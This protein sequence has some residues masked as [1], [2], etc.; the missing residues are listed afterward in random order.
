M[1]SKSFATSAISPDLVRVTIR[2]SKGIW[3]E[4]VRQLMGSLKERRR[5]IVRI[6]RYEV[7]HIH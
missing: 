3:L 1:I 6:T 7:F 2:L 4:K 5:P